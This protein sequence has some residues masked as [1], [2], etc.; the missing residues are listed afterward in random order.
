MYF[1]KF[2]SVN[3][4]KANSNTQYDVVTDATI[5][6]SFSKEIK[7]NYVIYEEYDIKEGETPEIVA[8]KYYENA[9]YHWIILM[10]ND[11]IDPRFEWPLNNQQLND[12]VAAKYDNPEGTH[13][14]VMPN[15]RDII[16]DAD[17]PSAFPVSNYQYEDALNEE[18]RTIRILKPE[19]VSAVVAEFTSV[20]N[21]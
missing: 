19:F 20:I 13:H 9:Q 21:G 4:T 1:S 14:Y 5:R 16:V 10:I 17:Y 11:I 3:Y 2:P 18:K 12:Y 7:E 8:F 6:V 15:N